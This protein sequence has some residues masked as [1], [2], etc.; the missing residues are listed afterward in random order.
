MNKKRGAPTISP[1]GRTRQFVITVLPEDAA[2]LL[3]INPK[4]S[5]AIR[6]LVKERREQRT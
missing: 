3:A 2:Y 6:Q 4:I 1:Q 5:K